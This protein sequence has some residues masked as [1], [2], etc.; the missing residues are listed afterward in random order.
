M[1]QHLDAVA[2]RALIEVRP[3]RAR[4]LRDILAAYAHG[5]EVPRPKRGRRTR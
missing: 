5:T 1:E 2:G 4:E 3:Q